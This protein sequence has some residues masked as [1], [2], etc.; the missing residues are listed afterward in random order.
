[1]SS[2]NPSGKSDSKQLAL[3]LQFALFEIDEPDDAKR[4]THF[5][6]LYDVAPKWV[7]FASEVARSNGRKRAANAT[8]VVEVDAAKPRFLNGVVLCHCFFPLERAAAYTWI[9]T[10]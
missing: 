5:V 6:G 4:T 1:M 7:F 2:S 9:S 3:S 8:E 10:K